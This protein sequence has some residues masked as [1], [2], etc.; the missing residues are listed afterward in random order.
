[1]RMLVLVMVCAGVLIG[2]ATSSVTRDTCAQEQESHGY[3]VTYFNQ[4]DKETQEWLDTQTSSET[5]VQRTNRDIVQKKS[6]E[7]ETQE[8]KLQE[9]GVK[10]QQVQKVYCLIVASRDIL[11][12]LSDTLPSSQPN[13]SQIRQ[14]K[15]QAEV[16][17]GGSLAYQKSVLDTLVTNP[18]I[19]NSAELQGS[20]KRSRDAIELALVP[21]KVSEPQNAWST[22]INV[23]EDKKNAL[24][25]EI[26]L[27]DKEIQSINSVQAT[28]QNVIDS[29]KEDPTYAKYLNLC[30]KLDNAAKATGGGAGIAGDPV[31]EKKQTL[32]KE[33]SAQKD[34]AEQAFTALAA[35]VGDNGASP[36]AIM[37]QTTF[38]QNIDRAYRRTEAEVEKRQMQAQSSGQYNGAPVKKSSTKV[39]VTAL[40]GVTTE[41]DS[42]STTG[43]EVRVSQG[44]QVGVLGLPVYIFKEIVSSIK[45]LVSGESTPEL[46]GAAAAVLATQP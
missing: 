11:T 13:D 17:M 42:Y 29:I 31:L 22:I 30:E 3:S 20:V 33:L 2:C 12:R 7:K 38:L 10:L 45:E 14:L 21:M 6:E 15:S 26:N 27:L 40:I 9:A 46:A 32:L 36:A 43:G 37:A 35:A 24:N 8:K 34:A 28:A 16:A 23:I 19:Q 44:K 39:P 41:W 18:I 1:M 4:L 5:G 25:I